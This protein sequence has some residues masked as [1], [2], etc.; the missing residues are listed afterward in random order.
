MGN[1]RVSHKDSSKGCCSN[2]NKKGRQRE[3][4]ETVLSYSTRGVQVRQSTSGELSLKEGVFGRESGVQVITWG[5][6]RRISHKY[7]KGLF[8]K[9]PDKLKCIVSQL[10]RQ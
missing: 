7:K 6:K 2:P 3:R 8:G 9:F 4:K 10:L 1:A 5:G